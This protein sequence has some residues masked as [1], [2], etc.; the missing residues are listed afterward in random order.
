M[1][2]GTYIMRREPDRSMTNKFVVTERGTWFLPVKEDDENPALVEML[3]A[4]FGEK[5]DDGKFVP[6]AD[7]MLEDGRILLGY[8]RKSGEVEIHSPLFVPYPSALRRLKEVFGD[9]RVVGM[10]WTAS[11]GEKR[12]RGGE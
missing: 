1:R 8:V 7:S 3:R 11:T 10:G 12:K 4:I 5:L 2:V 6:Q 9:V